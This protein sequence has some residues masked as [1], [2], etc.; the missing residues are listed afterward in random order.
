M[1]LCLTFRLHSSVAQCAGLEG[2]GF[3]ILGAGLFFSLGR[4]IPAVYVVVELASFGF[5]FSWICDCC[6]LC[7]LFAEVCAS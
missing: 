1:L 6:D 7:S 5:H 2:M 3:S 4:S